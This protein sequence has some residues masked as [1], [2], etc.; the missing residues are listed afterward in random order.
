MAEY[1]PADVIITTSA[2]IECHWCYP[3][4][5]IIGKGDNVNV[6]LKD[7]CITN[8]ICEFLSTDLCQSPW[9]PKDRKHCYVWKTGRMT[10]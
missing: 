5:R 7:G 2:K 8:V 3:Q 10:R 1:W 9:K 6:I 4:D